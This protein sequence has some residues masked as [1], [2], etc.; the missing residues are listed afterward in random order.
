MV[1]TVEEK[2]EKA[3]LYAIKWRAENSDKV[4][5]NNLKS[6]YKNRDVRLLDKAKYYENNKDEIK[7]SV[8][9][10]RLENKKKISLKKYSNKYYSKLKM[11]DLSGTLSKYA[12]KRS[13]ARAKKF[14]ATIYMTKEDKA[15]IEELY[16]IARDATKLFGYDWEVDHIVP[17]MKGGLHKL[18]NLQVVPGSWNAAKRDRNCDTYWD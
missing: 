7:S 8:A 2:R 12:I 5:A 17:L 3:R 18:T 14:G 9:K 4:K 11:Y 13:L 16:T 1:M 15:K 6:Y 10:Y